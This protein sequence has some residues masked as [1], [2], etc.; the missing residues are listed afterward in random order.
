MRS[1]PLKRVIA[2]GESTTWGYSASAKEKC[3]VNLVVRTLEGFQGS[4][5]DLINQGIGSRV[6]EGIVR[7]CSFVARQMPG[8]SLINEFVNKYGNGPERPS[9]PNQV[10]PL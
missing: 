10:P 7:N 5:I 2:L 8:E 1:E 4:E 9:T 6:F 3:W